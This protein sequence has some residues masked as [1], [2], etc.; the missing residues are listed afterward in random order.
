MNIFLGPV[1]HSISVF[2]DPNEHNECPSPSTMVGQTLSCLRSRGETG[3]FL[4]KRGLIK[5]RRLRKLAA[6]LYLP[7]Q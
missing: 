2:D 6:T 5:I 3:I 4:T 7:Y 1:F